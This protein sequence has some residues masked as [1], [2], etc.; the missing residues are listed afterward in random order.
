MT[1]E[2][3]GNSCWEARKT[4]ITNPVQPKNY[5]R[6]VQERDKVIL[7]HNRGVKQK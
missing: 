4:R 6:T 1:Y 2:K 5:K 3:V 7:A